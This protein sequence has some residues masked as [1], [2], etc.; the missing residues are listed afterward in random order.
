MLFTK[1]L[2]PTLRELPAE[3]ETAS[4]KLMLRAGM[5]RKLASGIYSF[6]PL[7]LMVLRKVENIIREEMNR[8]GAQELF[9]PSVIP[10]ELWK[11]SGRWDVY[12]KE[13]LRFKDRGGRDF[14]LGPT[15]EEVITD[16]IRKEI[17]SYRQLPLNLY[18]IQTKFRDEMRPRSGLIRCREFIMKD[19]YS[20]HEDEDSLNTVYIMVF[21]SYNRIFKRCGLRFKAV[22]ADSGNIGGSSSYEFMVLSDSGEDIIVSCNSCKYTA[23]I[24]KA[25]GSIKDTTDNLF[26]ILPLEKVNTPNKKSV[27]EVA[28]FLNLSQENLVKTIIYE[29]E[30][31]F[32]AALI[33]GDYEINEIKLRNVFNCNT[34]N[35]ASDENIEK[36]TE[37][38]RGYSGPIFLNI[39]IIA[40]DSVLNMKNFVTGAN[41]EG[42]HYINVNIH[43][44]FKVAKVCDI[45]KI[46]YGDGCPKCDNG[47]LKIERGIE[48]GHTFKL[49]T[50]YSE[51]L[52]AKYLDKEGKER[53]I[54]MGCYGIGVGRLVASIIE[55][56]HDDNGIILPI[57]VAP[58]HIIVLPINVKDER[59]KDISFNLYTSFLSNGY[60]VLYDDRD[61]TPGIKFKDADL[62]G[63]P[64]I[65][66]VGKSF[67]KD[68][69]IEIKLR[70]NGNRNLVKIEDIEKE[71]KHIIDR[72]YSELVIS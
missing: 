63:I 3:A 60:E 45:K 4:H 28:E 69:L 37:S 54:I 55:Q 58:Y 59:I 20:F 52:N 61:E 9:L 53:V 47:I 36:I 1:F 25:E 24:E 29:T 30:N 66:I 8:I 48:V 72:E 43:R 67:L 22:E 32:I 65:I 21:E 15:H 13:L 35:L 71:I 64:I 44:D 62:L 40:D 5:I 31:G 51:A 56:N 46:R 57:S 34:L 10:A 17:R 14:C 12:G 26:Q 42:Y 11:E 68:G 70:K 23:N 33:R 38:P 49:G 50:K 6:L 41:E 27:E 19:A 7:G 2:I 16:I 39:P 18:Q